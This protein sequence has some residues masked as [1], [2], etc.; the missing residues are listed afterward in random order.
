MDSDSSGY[1][2]ETTDE[3]EIIF[4]PKDRQHSPNSSLIQP[5]LTDSECSSKTASSK[6]LIFSTLFERNTELAKFCVMVAVICERAAYYSLMGN[7]IFFVNVMLDY[8]PGKTT[9]LVLSF[10]G[11]TWLTCVLGAV[12]G[13]VILGR[14]RTIFFGFICYVIGFA[15]LSGLAK[16]HTTE[17]INGYNRT[18][19]SWL[20][21]AV[22]IISIGEGCFK[23]NISSFG[24]DQV[25]VNY[26]DEVRTFFNYL[27]W[28]INIGAFI[29]MAPLTLLQQQKGFFCGYLTPG[30]LLILGLIVFL[31]PSRNNYHIVAPREK[32]LKKLFK[33]IVNAIRRK[34]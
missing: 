5:L 25:T 20:C 1:D 14:F 4:S 10:L 7:L 17:N 18:I 34:R 27:Y 21:S 2:E 28:S 33:V 12:L 3:E 19:I 9:V 15:A 26:D 31:I 24:A 8:E 29:G 11:L 23:C 6:D 13:D 32:L 30:I 22:F 16:Y